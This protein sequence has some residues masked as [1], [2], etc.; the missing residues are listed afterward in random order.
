MKCII[1]RFGLA[2]SSLSLNFHIPFLATLTTHAGG[3][4]GDLTSAIGGDSLLGS[5]GFANSLATAGGNST[6]ALGMRP[7]PPESMHKLVAVLLFV[8]SVFFSFSLS[9]SPF[10]FSFPFSLSSFY[11]LFS[12]PFTFLFSIS[13]LSFPFLSSLLLF[14]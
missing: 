7:D 9:F 3:D 6:A 13:F 14:Y 5:F 12:S 11:F 2:S 4:Y 8:F 10:S 1:T